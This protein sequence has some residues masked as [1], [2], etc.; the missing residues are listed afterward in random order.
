[1]STKHEI[2]SSNPS[3]IQKKKPTGAEEKTKQHYLIIKNRGGG[4]DK[5]TLLNHKTS[6]YQ[7]SNMPKENNIK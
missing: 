5:T 2:L 3:T 4:K 1:M 6:I 7:V